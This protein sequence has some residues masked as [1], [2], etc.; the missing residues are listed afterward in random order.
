[1]RTPTCHC[2]RSS[3]SS[4]N[5][6]APCRCRPQ[7]HRRRQRFSLRLRLR[8]RFSLKLSLAILLPLP[9]LSPLQLPHRRRRHRLP[10]RRARRA[11]AT[12]SARAALLAVVAEAAV[13]VEGSAPSPSTRCVRARA[14]AAWPVRPTCHLLTATPC[15]RA[16]RPAR[17]PRALVPRLPWPDAALCLR[18][19]CCPLLRWPP[20][21]RRR[22][23]RQR[24]S[25]SAAAAAEGVRGWEL[26]RARL[27]LL[28]LAAA[29]LS[30]AQQRH[31]RGRSRCVRACLGSDRW[32]PCPRRRW[33]RTTTTTSSSQHRSIASPT[34]LPSRLPWPPPPRARP[35]V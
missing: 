18:C 26:P 35:A 32:A 9:P 34:R 3:T 7:L 31:Q 21:A 23:W 30:A 4:R 24:W 6:R 28:F 22:V 27:P 20:R 1:M 2:R 19:R 16:A 13:E 14:Q 33:C 25:P 11:I 12:R 15:P 5:R 10:S 17:P 8:L 29:P